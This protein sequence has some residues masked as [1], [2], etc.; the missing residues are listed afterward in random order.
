MP[1]SDDVVRFI[2]REFEESILPTLAEYVRIPNKSPLF[3]RDWRAA[4]HMDRAVALLAD[5]ARA[6][7]PEG[8]TLEVVRLGELTPVILVDV[9]ASGGAAGNVLFYGH[10]DKQPEMTGW[11]AGLD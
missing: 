10:L 2:D 11:R 5:W 7:L 1:V 4:G 8:A 3:E 9:P 6:R